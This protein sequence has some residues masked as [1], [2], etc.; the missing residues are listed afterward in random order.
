MVVT[1]PPALEARVYF[2]EACVNIFDPNNSRNN[3]NF[4]ASKPASPANPRIFRDPFPKN[5]IP[6]NLISPVANTVLN[7]YTPR[8]N[9]MGGSGAGGSM[10]GAIVIGAG[11]DSNNFTDARNH[12][13]V[14]DQGTIRID[15]LFGASDN[16]F[17]RYSLS[18]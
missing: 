18:S 14:Q 5:Q 16:V 13:N 2:S 15:R 11:I 12:R 4:D 7:K 10:G 6:S 8:P 1:V 17:G 3:P 9:S